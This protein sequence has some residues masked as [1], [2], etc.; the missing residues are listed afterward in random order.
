MGGAAVKMLSLVRVTLYDTW[1]KSM[2]GIENRYS[3]D[4]EFNEE[5]RRLGAVLCRPLF[6]KISPF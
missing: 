6:K 5:S 4:V 1:F 2:D 3:A